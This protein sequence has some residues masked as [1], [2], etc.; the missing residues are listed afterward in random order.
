MHEVAALVF[1]CRNEA[2]E[3][4]SESET[5][6]DKG[7][8]DDLLILLQISCIRA[9]RPFDAMRSFYSVHE[10]GILRMTVGSI[11]IDCDMLSQLQLFF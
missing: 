9:M 7:E 3:D 6:D 8:L 5:L 10:I 2:G 11:R 4:K 1:A